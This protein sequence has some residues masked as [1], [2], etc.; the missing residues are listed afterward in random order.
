MIIIKALKFLEQWF[1]I[2]LAKIYRIWI[3]LTKK[4]QIIPNRNLITKNYGGF[5]ML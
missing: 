1:A 3:K 5:D 4:F 2:E